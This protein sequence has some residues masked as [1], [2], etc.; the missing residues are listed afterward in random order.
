MIV[1]L[2]EP[3]DREA[4]LAVERAAFATA[5]EAR[6]V[7]AVRDEPG[8]FALVA[9]EDDAV[10]GHVQLSA[11]WIGNE[12]V[13]ALGPIGVVPAR[14]GKGI[15][16]AMVAA[17]LAQARERRAAAVILLGDPAFYGARGFVPAAPYGLLNPFTGV[18]ADGFRIEEEDLQI[19]VL[20]E[21]RV[22][23]MRGKVR[24]HPA[25]G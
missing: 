25:F 23:A 3:G 11:A 7:A 4:S 24:W 17:A 5:D 13:L 9:E 22:K 20:D 19:A 15:G 10:V 14:Q 6:I 16:T 18:Q 2:E 1:R 21:E 8:S 12:A